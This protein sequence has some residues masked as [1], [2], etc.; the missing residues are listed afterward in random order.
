VSREYQILTLVKD[1]PY[2][3][4]LLDLFYTVDSEGKYMQNLVQE[5]I[6]H[7]LEDFIQKHVEENVFIPLCAIKSIMR[8]LLRA[9]A[10]IHSKQIC[11]RDLKPDNILLTN[12][13]SVKLCDFG[14]AKVLT[15]DDDKN[16]SHVMNRYYRAPELL[17]GLSDYST[18]IDMWAAGCI[19]IEMFM[20]KPLF[21]GKNESMQLFEVLSIL[22]T[23]SKED[24]E[25]LYSNLSPK[26]KEKINKLDN[27]STVD[28]KEIFPKNYSKTDIEQAVDL[29]GKML[30]W[31]PKNRIDADTASKHKFFNFF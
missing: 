8:Q 6:P 22:G 23:P 27:F 4:Q 21:P 19:F 30:V 28:F 18:K 14:S 25:Y 24:Q 10:F 3:V 31:D 26:I 7:C 16:I 13:L 9:L 5:F 11:H 20:K 17:F 2:C 15:P 12:D 1:S 29:L